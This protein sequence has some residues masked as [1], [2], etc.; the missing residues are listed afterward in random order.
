MF[1]Y[2]P[3][4][5][6]TIL[7]SM[8][9]LF[10][11]QYQRKNGTSL[12]AA[13]TFSF[14]SSI[15]TMLLMSI[16]SGFRLTVTPFS[17]I[18]AL[19]YSASAISMTIF[20]QKAFSIANL[21]VYSV[22]S[23][24]GGMLLPFALGVLFYNEPL[25]PAKIICCILIVCA[26][27][28]NLQG[29]KQNPRAIVYY[30]AIFIFNGMA[31]VISKIHQSSSLPYVESANFMVLTGAWTFIITGA[32]LLIRHHKIS[33]PAGNSLLFIAGNGI[34]NSVGNLLLLIALMTLPASVQYPLVTGGVMVCAT[35]ISIIRR[36][37][38]AIREYIA[39][40]I[41]FL[42]SVLIVF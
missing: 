7:F 30:L 8:Q 36:E 9:F 23:M 18:M 22:F 27:L 41:A 25:S 13:L 32:I 31:G 10:S 1:A 2:I 40:A 11:Q 26:V 34:F 28:L 15:M 12:R 4:I 5:I 37:K 6:A 42:A 24:L 3:V 17:L 39:T 33:L 35:V 16:L 19:I 14:F 29:G 21:S 20:S 38:L